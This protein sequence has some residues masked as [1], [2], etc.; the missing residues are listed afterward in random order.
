MHKKSVLLFKTPIDMKANSSDQTV[1][2][3]LTGGGGTKEGRSTDLS[4]GV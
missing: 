1:V 2:A 4:E 3:I